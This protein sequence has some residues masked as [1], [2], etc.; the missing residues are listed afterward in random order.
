MNQSR[1][2]LEARGGFAAYFVVEGLAFG[3]APH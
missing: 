2:A 3:P 1:I